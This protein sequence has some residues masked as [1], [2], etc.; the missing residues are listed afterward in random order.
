M[1]SVKY[2]MVFRRTAFFSSLISHEIRHSPD[3][4]LM[5]LSILLFLVFS[6]RSEKGKNNNSFLI[7]LHILEEGIRNA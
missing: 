5:T 4:G 7:L 3:V 2:L 1:N 6:N